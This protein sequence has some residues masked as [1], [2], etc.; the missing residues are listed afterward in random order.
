MIWVVPDAGRN[1]TSTSARGQ[2]QPVESSAGR[3][4][5][6]PAGTLKLGHFAALRWTTAADAGALGDGEEQPEPLAEVFVGGEGLARGPVEVLGTLLM[7]LPTRSP[8]SRGIKDTSRHGRW[9]N[10]RFKT[11][12]E[13]LGIKVT[14]DRRIGWRPR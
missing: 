6:G 11:L 1:E 5:G 14:T 10:A 8:M 9:H 13:E 7:K 4:P 12:A 2:S 3:V